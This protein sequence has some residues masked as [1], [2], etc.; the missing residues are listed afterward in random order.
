MGWISEELWPI[1]GHMAMETFTMCKR[2]KSPV[3][4]VENDIKNTETDT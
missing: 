1:N 4:Y 2:Y 3:G